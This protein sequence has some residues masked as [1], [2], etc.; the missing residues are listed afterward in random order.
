MVLA[1][2]FGVEV[3]AML[4]S[5]SFAVDGLRLLWR[6]SLAGLGRSHDQTV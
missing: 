6:V 2:L 5:S 4:A 1:P 3:I